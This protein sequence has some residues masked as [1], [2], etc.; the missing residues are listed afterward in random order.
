MKHAT[1]PAGNGLEVE[2]EQSGASAI[3][4]L[5]GRVDIDSSPDLR[6]RLLALLQSQSSKAVTVDLAEVPYIDASGIATFI[7]ALKISRRNRL[8]FCLVGLTGSVLHLFE[9][10]GV[11]ALFEAVGC[12]TRSSG[13]KVSS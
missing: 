10:T 5:R 12:P 7:E 11:L 1:E 13:S 2:V 4:R 3:L 9:V 6:D 8:E